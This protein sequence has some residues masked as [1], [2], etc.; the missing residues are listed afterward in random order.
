MSESLFRSRFRQRYSA[1]HHRLMREINQS[2]PWTRGN[3]RAAGERTK[4]APSPRSTE[5]RGSAAEATPGKKAGDGRPQGPGVSTMTKP[6]LKTWLEV[7]ML[8]SLNVL[9]RKIIHPRLRA[10]LKSPRVRDGVPSAG[11]EPGVTLSYN[12]ASPFTEPPDGQN[13]TRGKDCLKGLRVSEVEPGTRK[14]PSN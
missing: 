5:T 12:L 3:N 14:T 4:S 6:T 2:E 7:Q 8:E 9:K 1:E 10:S 13:E 11:A